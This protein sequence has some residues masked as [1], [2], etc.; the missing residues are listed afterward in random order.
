MPDSRTG[1]HNEHITEFTHLK[2]AREEKGP[3][4]SPA[5]A[6]RFLVALREKVGD[7]RAAARSIDVGRTTVYDLRDCSPAFCAAMDSIRG[8]LCPDKVR[9]LFARRDLIATAEER[10]CAVKQLREL[11]DLANDLERALSH[12]GR[13]PS[14]AVMW[15]GHTLEKDVNPW[16]VQ[17]AE[18]CSLY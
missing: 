11:I 5:W 1:V 6:E 10:G 3:A 2:D 18:E 16:L 8:S 14:L 17:F 9:S 4:A 13:Q 15:L 7:I 12:D